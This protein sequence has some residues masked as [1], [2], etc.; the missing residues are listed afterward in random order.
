[1]RKGLGT[2][3]EDWRIFDRDTLLHLRIPF[4][5]YLF[6]IYFFSL[7]F[8]TNI[9]WYR[10]L[11]IFIILHVFI[12]S[13]SNSYN[14]YM[15][16]DEGSIGGLKNPPPTTKKLLHAS[17]ICDLAGLFFA[18]LIDTSLAFALLIYIAASKAYSWH[19]IRLKKH[20]IFSW[21]FVL[22]FQGGFT[23]FIVNYFSGE[24]PFQAWYSNY[25]LTGMAIASL[26]VGAYYPL[27][28]VYQ[29]R[30]DISRGDHT[31]SSILGI[32]GTF[33]FSFI[34]LMLANL[35]LLFFLSHF[36]S[37]QFFIIYSTLIYPV[38]LYFFSWYFDVIKNPAHANFDRTMQLNNLSTICMSS[39]FIIILFLILSQNNNPL[40]VILH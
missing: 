31:I 12:Y 24:L 39:C 38:A 20:G 22:F 17:I 4:S 21:F 23:Y 3:S 27:T 11:A 25:N 19:G 10:T 29:H 7:C 16:K 33:L 32:R 30:E 18:S 37:V 2:I 26:F 1:M 14:S 40:D 9:D 13:G 5:F 34:I 35:L 28:Q 15:D 6:P 8:A 36:F